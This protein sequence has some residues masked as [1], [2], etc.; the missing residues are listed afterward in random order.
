ME[1][2]RRVSGCVGS[3]HTLQQVELIS[4]AEGNW[5]IQ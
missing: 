4:P 5:E 3:N 1:P 2:W